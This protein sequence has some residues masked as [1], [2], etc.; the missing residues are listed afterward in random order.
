MLPQKILTFPIEIW[1]TKSHKELA[2]PHPKK[3]EVYF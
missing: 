2:K 1:I 3:I